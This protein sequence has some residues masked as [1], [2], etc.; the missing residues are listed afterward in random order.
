MKCD[1]LAVSDVMA[2]TYELNGKTIE[3]YD[4]ESAEDESVF[5]TKN[6]KAVKTLAKAIEAFGISEDRLISNNDSYLSL[7][8]VK[9]DEKMSRKLIFLISRRAIIPLKMKYNFSVE[10]NF[11]WKIKPM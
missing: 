5:L 10:I 7:E 4:G 11:A 2:Y 8:R 1:T 9:C 6:N 3:D